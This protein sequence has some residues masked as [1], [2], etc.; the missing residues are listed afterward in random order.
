MTSET[1]SNTPVQDAVSFI[2]QAVNGRPI[3]QNSKPAAPSPSSSSSPLPKTNAS[4]TQSPTPGQTAA[5]IAVQSVAQSTAIAIADSTDMLRNISTIATTA[6]G[7]ALSKWIATPENVLY[8][9]VI[10]TA[11]GLI[12]QAADDM[13]TIGDNAGDVLKNYPSSSA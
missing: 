9:E 7:I 13:K 6:I 1:P 2:S 4:S 3:L 11:Q 10:S 8:K 12:S 5:G